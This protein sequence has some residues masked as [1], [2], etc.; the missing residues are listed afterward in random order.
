M[1][2]DPRSCTA[3]S[4]EKRKRLQPKF[5]KE[6]QQDTKQITNDE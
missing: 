3:K 6:P 5:H 1:H 2:K 4:R